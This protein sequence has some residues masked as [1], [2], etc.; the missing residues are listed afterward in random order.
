MA[1]SLMPLS[2]NTS[3]PI[4]ILKKQYRNKLITLIMITNDNVS[5]EVT[6]KMFGEFIFSF[7]LTDLGNRDIY[8]L[9]IQMY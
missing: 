2:L 7:G 1:I 9:S 8:K 5:T 4:Y 6:I 3:I